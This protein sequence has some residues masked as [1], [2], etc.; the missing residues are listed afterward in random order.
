MPLRP[1]EVS[2]GGIVHD[3]V[4]QHKD[5]GLIGCGHT[6][7]GPGYPEGYVIVLARFFIAHKLHPKA[8][9]TRRLEKQINDIRHHHGVPVIGGVPVV[10]AG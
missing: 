3:G 9:Y 8:P 5:L 2:G 10:G 4:V 6:D 1:G 7:C